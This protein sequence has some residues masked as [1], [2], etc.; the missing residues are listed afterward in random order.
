M[1][2]IS[3]YDPEIIIWIDESDCDKRNSIRKVAYTLRGISPVYYRILARGKR[4]LAI[5]G[6]SVR[7]VQDVVLV[8]GNVNGE[9]FIKNSL[10][11]ILQPTIQLF[12]PKLHHSNR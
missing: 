9:T 10:V 7:G 6:I 1:A 11:P 12:K 4:Y 3:A 8:E 2:N 5:T